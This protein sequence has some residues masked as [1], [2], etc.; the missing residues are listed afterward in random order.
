MKV[1]AL[2]E[3]RREI[4]SDELRRELHDSAMRVFEAL[5]ARLPGRREFAMRRS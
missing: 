1:L 5:F 2:R 4:T 3:A